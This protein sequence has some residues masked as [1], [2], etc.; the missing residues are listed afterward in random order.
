M[1][2]TIEVIIH[3]TEESSK[4]LDKFNEIFGIEFTTREVKGHYNNP[5]VLLN[6]TLEKDAANNFLKTLFGMLDKYQ[7]YTIIEEIEQRIS[8]SKF[9]LRFSK[10]EF[11]NGKLRFQENDSIRVKIQTP[12]YNKKDTTETFKR[13]FS[14][15]NN[16]K[17]N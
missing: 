11:L 17:N 16:N 3:A 15:L 9:H 13:I 8:D 5:I 7:K 10:Q 6:S 14:Q 4:F 2:V 12:I 1:K